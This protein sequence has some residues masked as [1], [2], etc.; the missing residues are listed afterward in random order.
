MS[1]RGIDRLADESVRIHRNYQNMFRV[2]VVRD[3]NRFAQIRLQDRLSG[4]RVHWLIAMKKAPG[5]AGIASWEVAGR[6][7]RLDCGWR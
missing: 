2:A 4:R 7:I 3:G 6:Q 5:E 1:L